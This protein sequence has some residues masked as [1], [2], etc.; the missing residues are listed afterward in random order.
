MNA[1][2]L[3]AMTIEEDPRIIKKPGK[4]R[5]SDIMKVQQFIQA[6]RELLLNYWHQEPP[7]D[8]VDILLKLT[9]I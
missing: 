8:T 1:S 4:M 7:L 9:K 3:F 6:N 5:V 2:E